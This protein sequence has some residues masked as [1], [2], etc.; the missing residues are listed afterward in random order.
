MTYFSILRAMLRIQTGLSGA[1]S[2]FVTHSQDVEEK[3]K[4][5]RKQTHLLD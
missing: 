4:D 3:G 2:H 1:R 5:D